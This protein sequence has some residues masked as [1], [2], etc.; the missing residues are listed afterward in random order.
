METD[1]LVWVPAPA[2]ARAL[3]DSGVRVPLTELPPAVDAAGELDPGMVVPLQLPP[4]GCVQVFGPPGRPPRRP[5]V[6]VSVF[7]WEAR[8]GHDVLLAA[9]LR[10]FSAAA[11]GADAVRAWAQAALGPQA[12]GT[13]DALR[14]P[15]VYLL[16]GHLPRQRYVRLLAAADAFVLPTRGEGW[17]LPIMEAM[18][19]GLPVIATNWSGPT[20]Y[21]DETVG[22]PLSY[23]LSPVPPREPW[24]F[25]GS[26]WAEPSESHLRLLMAHVSGSEAGRRGAMARGAAARRRVLERYSMAAAA[27]RLSQTLRRIEAATAPAATRDVMRVGEGNGSLR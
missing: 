23:Q 6:F 7:K 21:L 20:A 17:G 13:L 5:Y 24:W 16:S 9:F 19:L 14:S 3:R 12:D 25:Q 8:K 15:R 22:Y 1:G 18:A 4:P 10:Q 26:R 2:S 27:G 11:G